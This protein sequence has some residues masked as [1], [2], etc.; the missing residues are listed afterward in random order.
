MRIENEFALLLTASVDPR[1]MA[2]ITQADPRERE[3][4]Y[5][6][7][8]R[9]YLRSHPDV[10]KIIFTENSGW[11]LERFHAEVSENNPHAKDV[12]LLSVNCND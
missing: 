12:E 11:P 5:A 1:G 6:D 4:T 10:R 8:L 3:T 7:C 2:G 9:F